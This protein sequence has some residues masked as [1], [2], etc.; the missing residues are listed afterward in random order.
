MWGIRHFAPDRHPPDRHPELGSGS[1]YRPK[2][3]VYAARWM[4]QRVQHDVG[5]KRASAASAPL[6]EPLRRPILGWGLSR[7]SVKRRY[8]DKRDRLQPAL[9]RPTLDLIFRKNLVH[10][11]RF[12]RPALRF[13]V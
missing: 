9:R 11:E 8:P 10:P 3:S 7:L 6:R 13:V 2:T 12:E 1:I 4:L 5:E